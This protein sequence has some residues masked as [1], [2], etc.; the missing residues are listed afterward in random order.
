M[1]ATGK[2]GTS[3]RF[4]SIKAEGVVYDESD[5]LTSD[6]LAHSGS[7]TIYGYAKDNRGIVGSI[8]ETITVIGYSKPQI[9]AAS[10]E[11]EVVAARCDAD[12][13]LTDSGTYLKIKAKRSYSKVTSGDVQHNF[14]QIRYRYKPEGGTY[15]AWATILATDS[16]D[17]DDIVTGALLGGGLS[18][19]TAYLVQVQAIDDIGEKA[20][21]T[22]V[23]PTDKVYMHR[24]G[25]RNSLGIGKYVEDDNTVD[26]AEEITVKTRGPIEALGGGN[27]DILTLGGKITATEAAPD[28]LNDYKTPGSYYSPNAENSQYITDSPYTAGG[29]GMTVRQ[30]QTTGYIR[31]EI[32]YGRTTWIRHWDGTEWSDWWRYLTTTQADTAAAD[33]VTETGTSG[34]WTY[35]KWKGGTYEAFGTFEVTPTSSTLNESLY[36]TNNMT[37]ALPFTI[38]S[39]YV[40]G[41]AVGHYWITNGGISG[42][43]AIS[44]RIMSDKTVSTTNAIEVRL[45]VVGTYE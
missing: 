38:K 16:L 14:C 15:S 30:I 43:S 9:L 3:I 6:Y 33:Y 17:S 35:K 40:S 42:D 26:I 23:V 28:S 24:D 41:T 18:A 31:Q 10:G 5:E 37:I 22:I 12:G 1:S 4:Y 36:R 20:S 29:F 8:S 32:F 2:Y 25:A 13:N 19:K 7:A 11:S 27:I 21:T 39:A 44:L 45:M 34:G